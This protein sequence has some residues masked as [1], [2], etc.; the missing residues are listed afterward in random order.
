MKQ[1]YI[2]VNHELIPVTEEVYQ[3]YTRAKESERYRARRDGRCG[4]SNYHL[5]SGDCA[6]C[7]WQQEG[8][9][10]ISLHKALGPEL[11]HETPELNTTAS[12]LDDVVADRLLLEQLYR[13]LDEL[14]P[15]GSRVF[16][17]RAENYSEREIARK[18]G[19]KSQSTLN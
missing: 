10:V 16:R 3:A 14:I 11:E 6:S 8:Y 12:S 15:D 17:L 4:Q 7:P 5:C 1:R 18:L 19:I 13:Q 9:R 2:K